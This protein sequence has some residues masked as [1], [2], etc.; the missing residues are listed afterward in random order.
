MITLT[1]AD[2]FKATAIER[3][4]VEWIADLP[5]NN[6][7]EALAIL[8]KSFVD[9]ADVFERIAKDMDDE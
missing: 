1:K 9:R 4:A 2:I 7:R 3:M 6:S 5:P 8:S